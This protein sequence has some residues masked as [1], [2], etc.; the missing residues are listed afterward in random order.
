M[1]IARKRKALSDSGRLD[2]APTAV[3]PGAARTASR[4]CATKPATAA[5]SGYDVDGSSNVS[6]MAAAS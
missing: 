4:N 5:S 3:V 6:V 1:A 2:V